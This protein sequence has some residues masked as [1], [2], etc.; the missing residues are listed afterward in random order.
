MKIVVFSFVTFGGPVA[1]TL[2]NLPICQ[3]Y[4]FILEADV[5]SHWTHLIETPGRRRAARLLQCHQRPP[6]DSRM[7]STHPDSP[8]PRS[9]YLPPK[10]KVRSCAASGGTIP[11]PPLSLSGEHPRQN[12]PKTLSGFVLSRALFSQTVLCP[13]SIRVTRE[14]HSS[15]SGSN[16][17]LRISAYSATPTRVLSPRWH[18]LSA[19]RGPCPRSPSIAHRPPLRLAPPPRLR[20]LCSDHNAHCVPTAM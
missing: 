4:V 11:T 13:M 2:L 12:T 18:S 17:R 16:S 1:F 9:H 15:P 5:K 14:T 6:F 19:R 3:W 8:S 20:P 10:F 7:P